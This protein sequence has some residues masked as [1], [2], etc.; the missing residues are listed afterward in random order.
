MSGFEKWLKTES[1]PCLAQSTEYLFS[2][3][4]VKFRVNS[5][6]YQINGSI[7]GIVIKQPCDQIKM[8]V[9][10]TNMYQFTARRSFL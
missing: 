5:L 2:F 8:S 3:W 6:L 4:W 9:K 10:V 7:N 1:L